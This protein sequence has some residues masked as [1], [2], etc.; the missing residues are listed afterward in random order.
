MSLNNQRTLLITGAA[1]FIGYHATLKFVK[2]NFF[3]KIISVDNINSY[4][5]TKLKKD[6]IK[7]LIKFK[8]VKF[9]KLD[10]SNFDSLKK[11]IKN[12]N[13]T[14]IIHLAAQAGV[15]Y[16]IYNPRVYFKSNILAFQNLLD[17]ATEQKIK[18]FV[19]AS[20][21][22]VYGDNKITPFNEGHNTDMPLSYYAASKKINEI[23]AHSYSAIHKL[24]AT[25]L[26]FFT[27]Y[28][29]YGR[30]D[31][32]YFKFT[33]DIINEEKIEL[34]NYGNHTRDFTHIDDLTR[35][36]K[37][38]IKKPSKDLV[39]SRVYNIGSA[40]KIKIMKL[41]NLIERYTNKKAKIK[42]IKKQVGDV[43]DTLSSIS[44]LKKD[45]NYLPKIK[46]ENGIKEFVD[47]YKGYYKK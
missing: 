7:N 22:S 33:K 20:S 32:S 46:F 23:L 40:K 35:V 19:Y 2:D 5:D 17:I 10:L 1:G 27:V 24:P 42:Y 28:G 39:P 43:Q 34:Y 47:W 9:V 11:L 45:F 25:G 30:P 37:K 13:I 31:M 12:N 14:H 15:R 4:Y 8:K 36:L 41:V 38:I 6:R 21:S 18:H 16:S 26:R 44:K 3:F 29:S